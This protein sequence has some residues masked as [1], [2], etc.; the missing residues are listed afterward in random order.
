MSCRS[1][2]I[3]KGCQSENTGLMLEVRIRLDILPLRGSQTY[4]TFPTV[5]S[6]A[7]RN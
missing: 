4:T 5:A 1:V 6:Q 3:S 7:S 2:A